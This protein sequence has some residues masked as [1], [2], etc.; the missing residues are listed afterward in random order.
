MLYCDSGKNT[1][2]SLANLFDMIVR[3]SIEIG[4]NDVM[5]YLKFKMQS[6]YYLTTM[7]NDFELH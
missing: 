1:K 6:P 5:A 7:N 2:I 4:E 3:Y